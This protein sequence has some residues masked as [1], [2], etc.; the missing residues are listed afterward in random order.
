M[1]DHGTRVGLVGCVKQKAHQ[2]APAREL[3]TS[4]LFRGRKAFVVET[5]DKWFILSAKY[6]LVT[7]DEVLEPYDES[8]TDM[9]A[10][11]RRAWAQRVLLQINTIGLTLAETIFEIHAGASYRN[12]GL[13]ARLQARGAAVE[14]V[15]EHLGQ[16]EQLAFYA[17]NRSGHSDRKGE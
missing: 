3:Y 2:P 10:T 9:T 8:L 12:F 6:G 5:C 4:T 15:A 1:N 17:N 13:T 7:P 14:I 11:A 16:G